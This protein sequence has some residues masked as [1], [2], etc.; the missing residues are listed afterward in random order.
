MLTTRPDFR[1][2][3]D[4]NFMYML[5]LSFNE[6]FDLFR[7]YLFASSH[8]FL[9]WK[10][11]SQFQ[12][13]KLFRIQFWFEFLNVKVYSYLIRT[14]YCYRECSLNSPTVIK[15]HKLINN[16]NSI[17]I[18]FNNLFG[19]GFCSIWLSEIALSNTISLYQLFHRTL[20]LSCTSNTHCIFVVVLL[21]PQHVFVRI[22]SSSLPYKWHDPDY[23]IILVERY[24]RQ[25][26]VS[27]D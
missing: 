10:E 4:Y 6:P 27:F 21:S 24:A 2:I 23:D 16:N 1:P 9:Y 22:I 5:A 14:L 17:I 12:L 13:W 26:T 11:A 3:C 19:L 7:I 8:S 18:K 20:K 15:K 25:L